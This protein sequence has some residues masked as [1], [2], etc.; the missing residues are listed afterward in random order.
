M[1]RP[2]SKLTGQAFGFWTVLGP[3]GLRGA[4]SLWRVRCSCGT[5]RKVAGRHL[6]SGGSTSCGCRPAAPRLARETLPQG[7]VALGHGRVAHVSPEDA[8]AVSK[9]LWHQLNGYA[10]TRING[11]ST[12]LHE[13]LLGTKLVDHA[14]GDRLNNRRENLRKATHAQN[15]QNTKL[16]KANTSGFKG[17]T[18][19]AGRWGAGIRANGTFTYLGRFTTKEEAARAYDAAARQLHGEFARLNFPQAGE[20]SA[21]T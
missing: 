20:R 4:P 11:R 21:R 12:Y 5:T 8:E 3:A 10:A 2:R 17:V 9:L 19:R 15:Q 18:F 1:G 14:D 6:T 16:S 7:Q 13:F